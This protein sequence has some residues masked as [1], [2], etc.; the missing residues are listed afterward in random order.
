MQRKTNRGEGTCSSPSDDKGRPSSIWEDSHPLVSFQVAL[1]GIELAEEAN[2]PR[3]S[4]MC[5]VAAAQLVSSTNVVRALSLCAA[6]KSK[7]GN[8]LPK[9]RKAAMDVVLRN[10]SRGVLE[11]GRTPSFRKALEEPRAIIVPTLLQGTTEAVTRYGK[12]GQSKRTKLN[13]SIYSFDELDREDAIKRERERRKRRIE[14]GRVYEIEDY[15]N[16]SSSRWK[17]SYDSS[18]SRKRPLKLM[19]PPGA[20]T[21]TRSDG[22]GSKSRRSSGSHRRTAS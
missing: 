13:V 21:I 1:A 11:L 9:L 5:E 2:I 14:S 20:K 19:P 4:L 15:G 6:Q 7:S 17:S 12:R 3:L 22:R 8:D 10:G 18:G 16:D